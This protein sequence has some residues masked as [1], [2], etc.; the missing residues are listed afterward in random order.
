[1]MRKLLFFILLGAS[2]ACSANPQGP[3]QAV[4]ESKHM[5]E[6]YLDLDAHAKDNARIGRALLSPEQMDWEAKNHPHMVSGLFMAGMDP[7]VGILDYKIISMTMGSD[8]SVI[9]VVR[10]SEIAQS[11]GSGD[12]W[13]YP[14]RLEVK[15]FDKVR[16]KDVQYKI[17][18]R[19][20]KWLIEYPP[21]PRV[22][23]DAMYVVYKHEIENL[24]KANLNNSDAGKH[25]LEYL[26]GEAVKL[27]RSK[28]VGTTCM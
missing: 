19:N 15:V 4:A 22:S 18:H 25:T 2:N 14:D 27:E 16:C 1:M 9:A 17:I 26:N 10:F 28:S 20:S 5:L 11:S 3:Q 13:Q 23:V 8:N 24:N 21:T 6:E 12:E 7:Y